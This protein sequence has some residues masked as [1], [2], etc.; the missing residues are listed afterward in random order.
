MIKPSKAPVK[1]RRRPGAKPGD[2]VGNGSSVTKPARLN[3]SRRSAS[4]LDKLRKLESEREALEAR[5]DELER[6]LHRLHEIVDDF[7]DQY[8]FAPVGYTTLTSKGQIKAINITGAR[9]LGKVR[10]T[11][12]HTPF[13]SCVARNDFKK[14]LDHM[15]ECTAGSKPVTTVL[16]LGSKQAALHVELLSV[17]VLDPQTQTTVYRT[18]MM[19]ITKRLL[20]E[21]ALQ[22]NE[23]RYR[24]LV[25]LSPD[26][27][28]V[29][30]EGWFVLANPAALEFFGVEKPEDILGR[31]I[32]DFFDER[33]QKI[34]EEKL[35]KYGESPLDLPRREELQMGLR[36][37][38]VDVEISA[39][40]FVYEGRQAM[41]VITRDIS[42]RKRAESLMRQ[43][44][45]RF[46]KAFHASPVAISIARLDDSR[47]IDV[48]KAFLRMFGF[49]REDVTGRTIFELN[50]HVDP[51]GRRKIVEHLS[52]EKSIS[53]Y[54]V[55]LKTKAGWPIDVVE[56]LELVELAGQPCILTIWED[57]TERRRLEREI[58]E[59]SE[60]E[61]S[62]VGQDLHDGVCQN[63]AGVAFLAES[64]ANSL[65]A[66][67]LTPAAASGEARNLA[68]YVRL[69]IDEAHNL[70]TGLYPVKVEENGLMSAL[71]E[72]ATDT[73]Q[74]FQVSCAFKCAEP[75]ALA[76][77]ETAT[78]LYRI[79]QEAV[80]N[81]IKHGGAH[82]V[83]VRLA[84]KKGGVILTVEDNG[85]G[86]PKKAMRPGMGLKT[87]TYRA[88]VIG[89]SLEISN[90]ST[91]GVSVSCFIPMR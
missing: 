14:F 48:N 38:V 30:C 12:I 11:L 4:I 33:A 72:L 62:R 75:V 7:T 1:S 13:L 74:R 89:G 51:D 82:S 42:L 10:S 64:F 39:C 85:R 65:A 16:A 78:H 37:S 88:R 66:G 50:I 77:N 84:R 71:Q 31:N 9:M 26:A 59:I 18:V 2:A 24:E 53:N 54:E 46:S 36:N 27:I 56:S 61:Q 81:A 41:M 44:E 69:A 15:R 76:S 47:F 21:K 25:E 28:W 57:V 55:K 67:K 29:H 5:A 49:Q 19:D 91:C 83:E 45:E 60:R 22:E 32:A 70:A 23:K 80:G 3:T 63:L 87:M 34:I 79:A 6:R 35:V 52:K 58:L 73:A 43:A 90:K 20:V 86:L 40:E 17:P 8:D 68:K